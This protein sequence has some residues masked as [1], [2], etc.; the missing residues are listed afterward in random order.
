MKQSAVVILSIVLLGCSSSD[1]PAS[2]DTHLYRQG[3]SDLVLSI[4]NSL[5]VDITDI[6][7]IYTCATGITRCRRTDASPIPLVIAQASC[8]YDTYYLYPDYLPDSLDGIAGM[9]D[10]IDHLN[11]NDPY[12]FY[13]NPEDYAYIIEL[14]A[15]ERAHI[16]FQ[17]DFSGSVVSTKTPFRIA[18]IYPFTRAWIDGLKA[19]D[20]ILAVNGRSIM[21][22]SADS[23]IASLPVK[24]GETV[25]ITVNRNGEERV[26]ATAA[27]E[28][29]G[30]LLSDTMA[31]LS[32]RRFTQTTG[33]EFEKDLEALRGK[34]TSVIHQL[35]ID[36]R[37]NGGGILSG[38]LS[39]VDYLISED[40]PE[41]TNPILTLDGTIYQNKTYYLGN[42]AADNIRFIQAAD[43][44]L[45]VDEESASASEV[46]AAALKHY[47][48]AI[49]MGHRTYGKG[50][51]QRIF[52]LIDGSGVWI[53]AHHMYDPAGESYHDVGIPV[54]YPND[55]NPIDFD[56]DPVLKSAQ[57]FLQTG[58]VADIP[59][60]RA[61]LDQTAPK[62]L[63]DPWRE[64]ML[65]RS[66]TEL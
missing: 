40:L 34:T 64:K 45:L 5:A 22:L 55:G 36:L 17:F 18:E 42:H 24:E 31:Y 7:D 1:Q 52:D 43:C 57:K 63:G 56:H 9:E 15:G 32:I 51:S 53:T 6:Q 49:L 10:Y 54:D 14:S 25:D 20:E 61:T 27:E 16:G 21:G 29:I 33:E 3:E 2:S 59:P 60:S 50:V 65:E 28:H 46:V 47:R 8:L 37:D 12:T 41:N 13:F 30:L 62:R 35:I 11:Q 4:P 44:I 58:W 48:A 38:A 39:L 19:G 23:V 66:K 26:I